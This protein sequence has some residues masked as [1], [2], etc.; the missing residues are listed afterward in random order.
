MSVLR[1]VVV[2]LERDV[3]RVVEC[4]PGVRVV[5]RDYDVNAEDLEATENTGQPFI[6]YVFEHEPVPVRH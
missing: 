6:E 4:P 5:V 3:V 2:V 1:E